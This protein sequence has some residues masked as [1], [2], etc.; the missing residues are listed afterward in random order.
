VLIKR[1]IYATNS[2]ATKQAENNFD[3]S[4]K[5]VGGDFG[6]VVRRVV[7]AVNV[8]LPSQ[9]T[10]SVFQNF[11]TFFSIS[12]L[13][14]HLNLLEFSGNCNCNSFFDFVIQNTHFGAALEFENLNLVNLSTV[15]R[16]PWRHFELH[17]LRVLWHK[18]L[19]PASIG[20]D[21]F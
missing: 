16:M 7:G 13:H 12:I 14:N 18:H 1:Q 19:S 21:A 8:C 4:A 3:S 5:T 6:A 11:S 2:T 9:V 20:T 15:I 10:F 17:E